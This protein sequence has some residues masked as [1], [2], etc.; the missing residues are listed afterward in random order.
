MGQLDLINIK[1]VGP[2]SQETLNQAGI[3]TVFDLLFHLPLR[4]QD[5]TRVLAIKDLR[6]G[7]EA[8]IYAQVT[9][10]RSLFGRKPS[11]LVTLKDATGY[12]SLRFFHFNQ[13]QKEALNPNT[14]VRCFGQVRQGT[15]GLEMIHPRYQ[16]SQDEEQVVPV[17]DHLSPLYPAIKGIQS[18]QLEKFIKAAIQYIEAHN[19]HL[20][21]QD[22]IPDKIKES[23]AFPDLWSSIRSIHVPTPE[24]SRNALE[25]GKHPGIQRLA[26][27][28]LLAHFLSLRLMRKKQQENLAPSL[29]TNLSNSETTLLRQQLLEKLPFKLTHAQERVIKEIDEDLAQPRPMMRMLQGDVGSGKTIVALCAMLCAVQSGKQAALMAPTE[30]LANQ[31]F[32]GIQKLVDDLD[33]QVC[34]L[35]GGNKNKE[36]QK[37]QTA[38][39]EGHYD[40]VIGTHALFQDDILFKN[41]ALVVIDEQHRFGVQQRY[42]LLNKGRNQESLPHQL[43]MTAT[44]IPR[45]LAMTAYAD[46]DSSIIDQRPPGRIPVSTLVLSNERREEVIRRIEHASQSG[47]Q[48]YWVCSVIEESE[49]RQAATAAV[50]LLQQRLPHL[51]IALLHGRMKNDEKALIMKQFEE[52]E[53]DILVATTVVEVG[54]DVPNASVMVIENAEKL[55]LSQ[56]HQLRGRVGRGA[57]KSYCLLLYNPPLS[58]QAIERLRIMR[59]SDDGFVIAQRDLEL[60]GP[61]EILGT[62]QTGIPSMRIARLER[63][64]ALLNP[65]TQMGKQLLAEDLPASRAIIQRWLP[66]E[67]E[68]AEV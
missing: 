14:Y 9:Q 21:L 6:I 46:L 12:I 7:D 55:G 35:L 59:E 8:Y 62:R 11:L 13:Q 45:T 67:Q 50:E 60:R 52:N 53:L 47:A 22:F 26:F 31:H 66:V 34:L 23:F 17:E 1:G 36:K 28:E 64:G 38:I 2:R 68:Y 42:A 43:I 25:Q 48:V 30:I 24:I 32:K 39:A 44:P 61:G 65:V 56:L 5:R 40:I 37:L 19:L 33:L 63:D 54:V 29:S 4:Y 27:E 15:K 41:L 51:R 49:Q 10:Q 3:Y 20:G 58:E 18:R 16:T 57:R